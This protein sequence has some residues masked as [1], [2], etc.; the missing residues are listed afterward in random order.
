MKTTTTERNPL[1]DNSTWIKT[2]V[3]NKVSTRDLKKYPITHR[4]YQER[5]SNSRHAR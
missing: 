1:C 5:M 2:F 4:S 3:T